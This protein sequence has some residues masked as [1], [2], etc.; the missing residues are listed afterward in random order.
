MLE[1]FH[2]NFI[3]KLVELWTLLNMWMHFLLGTSCMRISYQWDSINNQL[4]KKIEGAIKCCM[5]DSKH[6][7]RRGPKTSRVRSANIVCHYVHPTL[8]NLY[9]ILMTHYHFTSPVRACKYGGE[10]EYYIDVRETGHQQQE[11]IKSEVSRE[12]VQDPHKLLILKPS[13]HCWQRSTQPCQV[14]RILFIPQPQD[15]GEALP[16]VNMG[17]VDAAVARAN[18]IASPAIA[19]TSEAISVFNE[20][21]LDH[22]PSAMLEINKICFVKGAN[23]YKPILQ[24]CMMFE[25]SVFSTVPSYDWW[26]PINESP[27]YFHICLILLISLMISLCDSFS[28]RTIIF[29]LWISL[30]GKSIQRDLPEV[31]WFD[32]FEEC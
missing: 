27:N 30:V 5:I 24:S 26:D 13:Y 23:Q 15:D 12:N 20:P 16:D 9:N 21:R 28:N 29:N 11:K 6:L 1:R 17:R 3:S 19:S 18:A 2:S 7:V 31:H 25:F 8:N 22:I 10:D 4:R 32:P 14:D